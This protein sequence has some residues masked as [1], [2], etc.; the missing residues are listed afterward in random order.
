MKTC[1]YCGFVVPNPCQYHAEAERCGHPNNGRPMELSREKYE[2]ITGARLM[3]SGLGVN[4]L[5]PLQQ[6]LSDQIARLSPSGVVHGN[7]QGQLVYAP[8][9]PKP[10][11][12][13]QPKHYARWKMQPIEFICINDIDFRRGAVIKYIMRHD[14][15]N[16]LEDLYKARSFLDMI[17]REAE[18]HPR[19]WEK[20]VSEER[21]LN[22][23]V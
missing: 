3:Q 13:D 21:K 4:A 23:K 18:G 2:E 12:V 14:A 16:G 20:P 22:A 6:S 1:D 8:N 5:G 10:D 17:I 19:F 9:P 15:K 7:H 11:A